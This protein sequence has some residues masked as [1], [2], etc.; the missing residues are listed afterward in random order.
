[1]QTLQ[2]LVKFILGLDYGDSRTNAGVDHISVF[3]KMHRFELSGERQIVLLN[4]G[5]LATTQAVVSRL[6]QDI[7]RSVQG[8]LHEATSMFDV[9][10][11]VGQYVRELLGEIPD[12]EK[13]KVDFGCTFLVGGHI[14]GEEPRLFLVY[15]EGNFIEATRETPLFQIGESKYGKPILDRVL[16]Y[17][18]SVRDALKCTLVSFDSTMRSNLS[19]G[20]PIDVLCLMENDLVNPLHHRVKRVIRPLIPCVVNGAKVCAIFLVRCPILI[21]GIGGRAGVKRFAV[22]LGCVDS[23]VVFN[24]RA[25]G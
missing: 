1:M 13:K 24:L 2:Q 17:H 15:P 21:G 10:K 3:S 23:L 5:N 6:R 14:L 12:A 9:A 18:L 22:D 16:H 25:K 20:Q 19:V 4:A 11:M 8:N 7:K